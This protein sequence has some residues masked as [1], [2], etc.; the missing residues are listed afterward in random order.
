MVNCGCAGVHAAPQFWTVG[1]LLDLHVCFYLVKDSCVTNDPHFVRFKGICF[2]GGLGGPH[3]LSVW[4]VYRFVELPPHCLG[5]WQVIEDEAAASVSCQCQP[6]S[7]TNR[8]STPH[9]TWVA[10]GPWQA[11]SPYI[12]PGPPTHNTS[13]HSLFTTTTTSLVQALISHFFHISLM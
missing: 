4:A 10:R 9:Q 8:A 5:G 11:H 12:T 13:G 1:Y 7:R 3:K 6:F 2:W